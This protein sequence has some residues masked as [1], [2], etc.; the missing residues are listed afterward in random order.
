MIDRCLQNF[1]DN[2]EISASA[3]LTHGA[4]VIEDFYSVYLRNRR[5]DTSRYFPAENFY[6]SHKLRN[7]VSQTL[8]ANE[9]IVGGTRPLFLSLSGSYERS[10]ENPASS[11]LS[12]AIL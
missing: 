12:L 9:E 6:L 4:H 7:W 3:F 10:D 5:M 2:V 8:K 1:F 11:N